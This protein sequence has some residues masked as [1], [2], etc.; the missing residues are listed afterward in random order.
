MLERDV[1][2]VAFQPRDGRLCDT[3][4]NSMNKAF[5]ILLLL[6]TIILD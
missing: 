2:I 6:L 5:V 1:K 3:C 4:S